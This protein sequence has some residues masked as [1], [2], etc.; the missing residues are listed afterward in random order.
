MSLVGLAL[1]HLHLV[2]NLVLLALEL[3]QCIL[4]LDLNR[5]AEW[6]QPLFGLV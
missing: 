4:P 6:L 2:L 5:Y 1:I 3:F